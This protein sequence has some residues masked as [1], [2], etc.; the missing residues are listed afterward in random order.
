MNILNNKFF[1]IGIVLAIVIG[2]LAVAQL[3]N[4]STISKPEDYS[5]DNP[6]YNAINSDIKDLSQEE[7]DKTDYYLI[8]KSIFSYYNTKQ[9][10]KVMYDNLNV[11]L[12]NTYLLKLTETTEEFCKKSADMNLWNELYTESSN[13]SSDPDMNQTIALLNDYKYIRNTALAAEN[14]GKN[15]KYDA[16]KDASFQAILNSFSIKNYIKDNPVLQNEVNSAI[17]ALGRVR[18][19]DNRFNNTDFKTC[20]CY[21][22]F[23]KNEYYKAACIMKQPN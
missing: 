20:N 12:L 13:F 6:Q 22:D 8:K 7:W 17:A 5:T 19:L 9:I 23:G 18:G 3:M 14:Y 15:E 11:L 16:T 2:L 21:D 4:K 1:I 10:D